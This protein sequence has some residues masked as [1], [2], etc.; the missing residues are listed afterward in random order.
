MI[1]DWTNNGSA[2]SLKL[3]LDADAASKLEF[4]NSIG[5]K[6]GGDDTGTASISNGTYT[7]DSGAEL[8]I[9]GL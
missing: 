9:N 1:N 2:G 3:T 6:Y 4:T 5:T 7:L 8:I